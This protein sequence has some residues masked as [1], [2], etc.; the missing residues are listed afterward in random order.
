MNSIT[1][2]NKHNDISYVYVCNRDNRYTRLNRDNK[3]TRLN[4]DIIFNVYTKDKRDARD[5]SDKSDRIDNRGNRYN[6]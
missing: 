5:K 4:R 3:Y 6:I 1:F 2:H